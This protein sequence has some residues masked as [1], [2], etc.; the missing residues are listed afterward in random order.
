MLKNNFTA[1]EPGIYPNSDFKKK[2]ILFG[3]KR[4]IDSNYK[5]SMCCMG[6]L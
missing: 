1:E 6:L 4:K 5:G 2:F 3:L